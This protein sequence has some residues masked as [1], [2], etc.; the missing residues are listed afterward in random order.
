MTTQGSYNLSTMNTSIDRELK[1]L[2]TQAHLTWKKE[3]QTLSELGLQD[4]M[5]VIELGCGPGFITEQLLS[6]L[7]NSLITA[8]DVDSVMIDH[9]KKY[10][11]S[12]NRVKFIE[13]SVMNTTLPDNSF[14]FAFA[15]LLFQHIPDP[16]GAASEIFRILKPGG[17][18][19]ITE[20]DDDHFFIPEPSMPELQAIFDKTGP[21]QIAQGGDGRTGR[22]LLPI[23]KKAG[24]RNLHLD[25]ILSQSEEENIEDFFI[26]FDPEVFL[27]ALKTDLL[28]EKLVEDYKRAIKKFAASP[29]S[30]FI[31]MLFM[32]CGEKQKA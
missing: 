14:D 2:R 13:T 24:F 23:L 31:L 12:Q 10:F 6:L 4:G 21:L 17:K 7:P 25:T 11:Q 19:V 18:L 1:R 9:A 28:A 8:M 20:V 3:A 32:G 5:S 30:F 26:M 22:K 16:I 29:Q 15:R 27:Q